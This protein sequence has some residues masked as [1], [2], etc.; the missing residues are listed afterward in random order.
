MAYLARR[1]WALTTVLSVAL[2]IG[3]AIS[4]HAATP[5][6]DPSS[7]PIPPTDVQWLSDRLVEVTFD[8]PRVDPPVD[9]TKVRILVPQ[10]WRTAGVEYPAVLLLHGAGDRYDAWTEKH[11]GWPTTLEEFSADEDVVI[12]MPDGGTPDQPGWYSDW[13]NGGEFGPPQWETWHIAQLIPWVEDAFP[14][15]DDRG[16]WVVAGLS[17]G[18]FGAMSYLAR[19][20]DLF[21]GAFSFSGALSVRP[22]GEFIVPRG[23]WGNEVEQEVRYRGHNPP[24]LVDNLHDAEAIWFRTGR[25]V[26]GGPAPKDDDPVGLAI[27]AGAWETNETFDRALDREDLPH[28]YEAYPMG[29]HNWWHWHDGLQNHAWPVIEEL[30]ART[31]IPD[32]PNDFQYRTIESEFDVYGWHVNVDRDVVEF[33]TL[34]DVD[35]SD[36]TITGSG[37]VAVTTPPSYEP[38]GSYR[39]EV[40]GSETAAADS[41]TVTADR[42]GRLRIAVT[43]GPSHEHQQFTAQQRAA[44]TTTDDYWQT[45][46]VTVSRTTQP[47][48]G[49]S[50]DGPAAAP[51]QDRA[52]DDRGLP[53][54][55]AGAGAAASAIL[56][57]A[58]S[59]RRRSSSRTPMPGSKPTPEGSCRDRCSAEAVVAPLRGVLRAR[60][61]LHP[62]PRSSSPAGL[63]GARARSSDP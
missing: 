7:E 57:S 2:V 42:S 6:P 19:H 26:P 22:E 9:P 44:E 56:L 10:D 49:R 24:D 61:S 18:G 21:A 48:A 59:L 62:W 23:V 50:D 29:G 27:E 1:S 45:A 60:W 16:G 47:P 63:P 51:R 46:T 12:V 39:V 15:R 40:S 52:G 20:P 38:G 8:N 25:G 30:F 43:L 41:A 37:S 55:G 35:A 58:L 3:T 33:L 28:H 4:V 17:M 5:A 11:D 36:L 31:D 53:A 32:V 34:D 13:F 54:T 14:V